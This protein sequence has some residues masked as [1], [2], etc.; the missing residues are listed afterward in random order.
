MRPATP[1]TFFYYDDLA[2]AER[3]YGEV[4]GFDLVEDQGWAKIYRVRDGAFV[5]IVDGARGSF[6]PQAHNAVLL[7]L[8]VDDVDDWHA[9]LKAHRV[10]FRT[11]LEERPAI[12]IRCFFVEDP[13]G[14]AIE[15][16]QF[17]DP[18]TAAHFV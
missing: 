3:F 18:D 5:G 8:V 15:I 4:L 9:H 12:G 11:E 1:I 14:Y 2:P 13:G 17:T 6:Q 16:Q 10:P 7:T